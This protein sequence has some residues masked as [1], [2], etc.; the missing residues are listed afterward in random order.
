MDTEPWSASTRALHWGLAATITFQLFTGLYIS[1]PGTLA[2]FYFHEWSGL[3]S[4]GVILVVWL[5]SYANYDL[6]L[7]FPWTRA[8]LADVVTDLRGLL[9]GTLPRAGRVRGLSSFVHGLGL[10]AVTGM[11]VTG[12]LI[13]LVI[14]GGH[15]ARPAS[16]D[17]GIFTSL[18]LLHKD[19]AVLVWIYWFGHIAFALAHQVRGGHVLGGIFGFG[20]G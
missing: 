20:R 9:R 10:L 6:P 17:Y 4:A 13:F 18:S 16:T 7:L 5:W 19:I 14:P 2:F 1:T 15:G 3:L 8:G 12:T 11:A